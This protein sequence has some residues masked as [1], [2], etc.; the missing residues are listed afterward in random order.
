MDK[1]TKIAPYYGTKYNQIDID[2]K[3]LRMWNS[4]KSAE[5][6]LHLPAPNPF[7]PGDFT[8]QA[9]AFQTLG[10][11]ESTTSPVLLRRDGSWTLWVSELFSTYFSK[12]EL[13]RNNLL[14][15]CQSTN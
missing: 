7:V 11:A 9:N 14:F 1:T 13:T 6:A 5:Q 4:E 12:P 2:E 10:S 15:F 3:T 8:L